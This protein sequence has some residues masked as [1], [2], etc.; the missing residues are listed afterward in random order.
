V[1]VSIPPFGT[2]HPSARHPLQAASI[3]ALQETG[4]D[5]GVC[6]NVGVTVD[7]QQLPVPGAHVPIPE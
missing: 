3:L 2:T 5:V 6:I 4:A 1:Q 7:R